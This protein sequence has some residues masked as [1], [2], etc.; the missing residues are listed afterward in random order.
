[1]DSAFPLFIDESGFA[2]K[3]IVKSLDTYDIRD[4]FFEFLLSVMKDYN[5]CFVNNFLMIMKKIK[6]PKNK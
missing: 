1:V 3:D 5:K 2:K 4:A 6:F